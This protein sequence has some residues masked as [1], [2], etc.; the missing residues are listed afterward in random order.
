L[1]I[2]QTT[3]AGAEE[4]MNKRRMF[5]HLFII[6]GLTLGTILFVFDRWRDTHNYSFLYSWVIVILTYMVFGGVIGHLL[7]KMFDEQRKSQEALIDEQ[8]RLHALLDSLPGLMIV[9]DEEHKIQF[10]NQ[11]YVMKYGECEGKF[12]YEVGDKN[13]SCDDCLL[14]KA[15]NMELPLHSEEV[16]RNNKIYEA[17]FH[18]FHNVD[19]SKL[20]IRIL[21]DITERKEAEQELSRLQS[22]MSRLERLNIVGQMAAGI[23]HEIRN[24]MTTVR[25]Y[26]QLLGEKTEF[27]A[28]SSTIELMVE[29]LDRANSIITEF[30]SFVRN[31][32]M[33]SQYQNINEILQHLYP[34]LEADA[35]TQNKQIKYEAGKTPDILVNSKEISQLILNLCRNGLEAMQ[36]GGTLKL[37]TYK[38][39]ERVVLSVEDE[40][41]GI[42]AEDLEKLGTPF[43][44][45]KENGTGLGLTTCYNIADRHK[46][47]ID[48]K[49]GSNG[50]TFF[51][52]FPVP[53]VS[54]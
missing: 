28:H 38:E 23:A 48:C 54:R 42:I 12:C 19:G 47:T 40:G 4:K 17:T 39:D 44:T 43:F 26:L 30:L 15:F 41:R 7:K 5:T 13:S 22:D 32:P 2:F 51:V 25:G 35:Y 46:A 50:T 16:I 31:N 6:F 3:K 52:R 49:S 9:I 10:A 36:E 20:V 18:P 37:R 29:E 11:N 1:I 34:L 21:Y 8:K 53:S 24:P 14:E 33:E 45:T 27:E